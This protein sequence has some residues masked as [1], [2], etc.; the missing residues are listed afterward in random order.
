M[1]CKFVE[2]WVLKVLHVSDI[3]LIIYKVEVESES[4]VLRVLSFS[5][6]SFQ[7]IPQ[8][9]QSAAVKENISSGSDMFWIFPPPNITSDSLSL[10]Q[11]QE[12][13]FKA[14]DKLNPRR[15]QAVPPSSSRSN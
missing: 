15:E 12:R 14:A 3:I 9:L 5:P 10:L 7:F 8:D 1:W 13:N 11:G 4:S 6:F 2:S